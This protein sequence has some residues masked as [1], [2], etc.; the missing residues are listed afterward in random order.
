M[1]GWPS[2]F[3]RPRGRH[4]RI[5]SAHLTGSKQNPPPGGPDSPKG[6]LARA[7]GRPDPRLLALA[8]LLVGVIVAAVHWPVLDCRALALDDAAFVTHNPLVT[9]PSWNSAGRFFGEVL[10]PSTVKGYYTPLTM[11]SLMLDYA[12]GGRPED[13]RAFHRTSLLLHALCSMLL[14]LLL[15]QFFGGLVP[16][17]AAGLVF[18]LHPLMVEPVAWIAER[19]TLLATLFAL[20]S[21]LGYLQYCWRKEWRWMAVSAALFLLALLSKP[22]VVMLPLLLL[23]LD[24]WP[25]RRFDARAIPEKW[26]HFLL[27]AASGAITLVSH[28]R[29]A[30]IGEASSS[31]FLQVPVRVGYLLSFYLGKI[32]WPSDLCI[33]YPPPDPFTLS[34][35]VVL[36][37][38]LGVCALTALLWMRP[39]RAR[40]PLACWLFF[41]LALAPTLGAVKYSWV[42]ASNKYVHF[43]AIGLAVLL[44]STLAAAWGSPR[45]K[46]PVPRAALA[47]VLCALLAFEA[48]G[49]RA[50]LRSWTDSLTLFRQA[51]RLAP[52]SSV[53]QN[54]LGVLL[55]DSSPEESIT[56]LQRAV[57]LEPAYGEAQY[58][59]GV[60]QGEHGMLAESVLHFREAARLLPADADAAYNLG[61]AV[62]LQGRLDE[63]EAQFRRALQLRPDHVQAMQQLAGLLAARGKFEAAIAEFRK[64][65]ALAPDDPGLRFGLAAALSLLGSHARESVQ[66]IRQALRLRPDW[67]EALN[68]LAWAQATSS[69]DSIRNAGEA[70]RLASQAVELT[71]RRR[72]D[73]LDTQ[74]SALAALGRFAEAARTAGE[75]ASMA[76]RSGAVSL[77][78]SI[79]SRAALYERGKAYTENPA[80]GSAKVP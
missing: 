50:A 1:R 30:G 51:A 46:A 80:Q 32:A 68:A 10:E 16:A 13:P 23:L 15:Y 36:G 25:L 73:I 45:L 54:E 43:P 62:R 67:P 18:G 29:T 28:Q 57:E 59:L 77:A 17:V 76:Q 6:P 79:R 56:H 3:S 34:N 31:D 12:M 21:M 75:A 70:L 38:V 78:A 27:A 22:T 61:A 39:R 65:V 5:R 14:A 63:A 8:L 66:Q 52:E 2:F 11:T 53:I 9:H 44:A 55:E 72:P 20:G 35:P 40:G 47:L 19:K 71:N 37:G 58:N 4:P 48:A 26:P 60:A 69:D 7:Q 74:A 41:V 24:Y 64:G 49:A 33:A 42:I